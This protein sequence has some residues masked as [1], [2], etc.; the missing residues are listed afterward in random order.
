MR[1][2]LQC[3]DLSGQKRRLRPHYVPPVGGTAPPPEP[4]S[5]YGLRRLRRPR[6]YGTA[7]ASPRPHTLH[8]TEPS[9]ARGPEPGGRGSTIEVSSSLSFGILRP[10][11]CV[12]PDWIPASLDGR[13]ATPNNRITALND[14]QRPPWSAVVI[15]R[16]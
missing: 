1:A 14:L 4:P 13:R 7:I 15:G 8:R 9:R 11:C 16:A 5:P 10:A 2:Y 3:F 6:R 12:G